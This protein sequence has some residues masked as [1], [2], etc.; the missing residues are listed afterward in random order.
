M[1]L[2]NAAA[3]VLALL[4]TNTATAL[5]VI[6]LSQPLPATAPGECPLLIK[7]KYPF[8]SC[9]GGQIGQ[10]DANEI[11]ENS[12]QIPRQSDWTEGNGAWGP[13]LNQN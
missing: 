3:A 9:A 1:M 4:I 7:I 8:L 11:W 13:S 2:R 6:D 10:T 5:E 12:R